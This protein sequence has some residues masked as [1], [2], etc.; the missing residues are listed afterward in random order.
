MRVLLRPR[1]MTLKKDGCAKAYQSPRAPRRF[2]AHTQLFPAALLCGKYIIAL[3]RNDGHLISNDV[4]LRSFRPVWP[5]SPATSST[6]F[7]PW[8]ELPVVLFE[9]RVPHTAE[10]KCH[11]SRAV[12][13]A[14]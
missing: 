10:R 5:F 4:A 1:R 3:T 12:E 8:A 13:G 14:E 6:S 11:A 9:V 7:L 2:S